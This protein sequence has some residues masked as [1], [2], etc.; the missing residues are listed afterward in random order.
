MEPTSSTRNIGLSTLVLTVI[1]CAAALYALS[2][3]LIPFMLAGFLAVLFKPLVTWFQRK[4]LPTWIGVVVVLGITSL[5]LWGVFTIVATGVELAIAKAP[6][7]AKRIDRIVTDIDR[8]VGG[9]I[10]K[11]VQSTRRTTISELLSPS[12]AVGIITSS[13]GSVVTIA[14]DGAMVLLYLIFMMLGGEQFAA[15]LS[16]AFRGTD[17]YQL[18]GVYESVNGKV[19]RY[20]RLKTL[21]NLL[22]GL[23]AWGIM[24]AFGLDFAPLIALLTF[25]FHYLPNIGSF[26]TTIIPL[27]V[28]L[29]QFSDL[30]M[31]ILMVSILVVVQNI[32]GNIL[33]PRAMGASL[34]LSPIVVLFALVFW[35]WMWGLVGMILSVPIV[36]IIK[37]VMEQFETTRPLAI[38]MGNK[39]PTPRAEV[40]A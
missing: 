35:G 12:T 9:A 5:A 21:F 20:L 13:V 29:V 32:I 16:A 28:G 30:A 34:D 19:L 8:N 10:T 1:A 11:Y 24:E 39:A 26:I 33:E 4:G 27:L 36:A 6:E 3:I 40:T 15:K 14:A 25:L 31:V 2:P 7:Y 17:A 37:A 38:L 22:N 23:L 18:V